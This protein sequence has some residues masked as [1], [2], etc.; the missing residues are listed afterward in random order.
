MSGMK[1]VKNDQTA[2]FALGGLGE[3][4][5]NTYAVQFQDEIVLIDAGIKFPEDELLGIDYVIPDYTY[6]VKN[7]DKIKGL[8]ITHGHEDHI[9]GIPYLLRQVNI[10]VYGGKLAIGLLRNKLEEHGLLRQTKLNIIGEDDIVKFRKTAVSFFRTTHSIPDSYGIVVK[11]PP[12]NIV[13]TGDFKFDFTPVGE[14]ANLTKMA[15]IGKEGVL[16]LLSDSTNSENPEF[17]MSERRVGESIHDI[18]RKVDGRIIFATFASNIHRLQQVIE[19]AVQNGRKVAVF[20]RSMES[21][22]EIGQTL[23]YINCP[24]IRLLSITKSIVCL[25]IK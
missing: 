9:G 22:I 15:E 17:T 16:C 1:F 6:L 20:G 13:H 24:K 18:F 21:A 4:G 2:V 25:L 10:P 11:T 12:G 23:G 3:I 19:A 14:P 7:E 8:F 5:K